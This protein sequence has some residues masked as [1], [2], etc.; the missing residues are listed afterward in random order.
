[1]IPYLTWRP[2]AGQFEAWEGGRRTR[3]AL[4]PGC[5]SPP[6]WPAGVAR[7]SSD[8]LRGGPLALGGPLPK[9]A[10]CRR[11]VRG[12]ARRFGASRRGTSGPMELQG[13]TCAVRHSSHVRCPVAGPPRHI[14]PRQRTVMYWTRVPTPP[15]P[16][17]NL[18]SSNSKHPKPAPLAP[19]YWV[20]KGPYLPPQSSELSAERSSGTRMTSLIFILG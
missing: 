2:L 19:K 11:C 8:S 12:V 3:M 17:I 16:I 15:S 13:P 20:F 6:D 1:M 14:K 4:P 7:C 5:A 9:P 10:V 18:S